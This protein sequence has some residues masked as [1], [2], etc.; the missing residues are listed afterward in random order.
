VAVDAHEFTAL[1]RAAHLPLGKSARRHRWLLG[2]TGVLALGTLVWLTGGQGQVHIVGLSDDG[3]VGPNTLGSVVTLDGPSIGDLHVTLD[4]TGAITATEVDGK[5]RLAAPALAEGAHELRIDVTRQF[6]SDEHRTIA[7]TVD[8]TPPA[9]QAISAPSAIAGPFDLRGST[10]PGSTVLVDRNPVPTAADGSYAYRADTVPLG[11]VQVTATDTAGN[12]TTNTVSVTVAVPATHGVHITALG[13]ASDAIRQRVLSM[14]DA[15]R[16]DTVELDV[17]D[18]SGEIGYDSQVPLAREIGSAKGYYD[19]RS[20]IADLH[21]RGVR[22]VGRIVAFRDPLL[23]SAAWARG[24]RDWVLQTP[25]G[26]PLD[27]YGG[28]T[29]YAHPSVRRYNL[30]IAVEAA[31]AGFDDILWD[32]M[33]R[34]EG[35]PS[36]MVV[37]G[38]TGLSSEHIVSFLAEAHARLRPHKV[39]QG[40][41]V[42]GI[43]ASRPQTIAQD[44]A[45]MAAHVEYVSPMVYPSHWNDGE[46]GVRD[47]TRQPADIVTASLAD[48]Q[49]V[50]AGTGAQLVPWF[51]DFTMRGVPYGAAEVRAQINAAHALGI[52]NWLQWNPSVTYTTDAYDKLR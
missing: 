12:I 52:T 35:N 28:F 34:P 2:S 51:Q 15:G 23:A 44:V 30:D 37:P 43:A 42:F 36:S 49:K 11:P 33:R 39:I 47:P 5:I 38:L 10:E 24:D 1:D 45:A 32:Y 9:L 17:K 50:L 3:V 22:V 16:I 46:Y 26:Q 40:V 13:W 7:F 25:E 31:E 6:R 29:N 41:S 8:A 21:G 18:E 19:V 48:F 14:I 27:S 20:A 4:G